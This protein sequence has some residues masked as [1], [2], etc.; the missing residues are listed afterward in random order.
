MDHVVLDDLDNSLQPAAVMRHLTDA[1]GCEDLAINYYEL[2]PGDSFAF[3]YHTHEVQEEVFVVLS[4]TAT[5][6]VGPE[7]EDPDDPVG[8]AEPGAPAE[9]REVE[10]GPMEAIRIPPGQFQRGWNFGE[11]RVTALALGAPLAYGEQLKRDDCPACGDEVPV[12]IE[13]APDD[14]AQLVTVCADCGAEVAR[15]R[16]GD[17]GENERVR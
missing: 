8:S 14:E 2:A 6:V 4:G 13:R 5:W 1:L 15:W 7:P 9:R 10:V 3:A 12:S 11:D 16:R 17:D